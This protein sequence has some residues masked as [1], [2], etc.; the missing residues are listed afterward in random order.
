[1]KLITIAAVAGAAMLVAAAA[2]AQGVDFSK[3]EITTVDLGN[4]TYMLVGMAA[5]SPSR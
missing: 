4:K 5:T 3:V 2:N 1:M